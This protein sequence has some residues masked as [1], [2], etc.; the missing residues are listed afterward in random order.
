MLQE[1]ATLKGHTDRLGRIAYHPAGRH[2]GTASFD[3][4]WR[5]WDLE[6][7]ACPG[8]SS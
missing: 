8:R 7:Q 1:L 4:T 3:A 2:L 6:T 5:L